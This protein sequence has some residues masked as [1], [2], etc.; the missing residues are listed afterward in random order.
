LAIF[1]IICGPLGIA[2]VILGFIG[3]QKHKQNPAVHGVAHAWIGIILGGVMVLIN[4][5]I[6][7]LLLTAA[8]AAS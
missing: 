7:L 2:S 6:L 3:L 8:A 4:I 1:S 5:A